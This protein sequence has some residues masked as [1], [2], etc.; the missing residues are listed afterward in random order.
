MVCWTGKN[1]K[2]DSMHGR[3]MLGKEGSKKR[4]AEKI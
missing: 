2:N 1:Q 3:V 4:G